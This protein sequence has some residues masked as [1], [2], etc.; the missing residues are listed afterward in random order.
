V[1]FFGAS[2][3]CSVEAA[4]QPEA[5]FI[6]KS[7]GWE[8]YHAVMSD[9]DKVRDSA[10]TGLEMVVISKKAIESGV[11]FDT[12]RDGTHESFGAG[13][14]VNRLP[15]VVE[16]VIENTALPTLGSFTVRDRGTLRIDLENGLTIFAVHL[17]SNQNPPCSEIDQAGD[18]ILTQDPELSERLKSYYDKG[19]RAATDQHLHNARLRERMM[20]AVLVE[21][22][23]AVADGR[24]VLITGDFNIAFERGKS[25]T[26]HD[27]CR[28]KDFSCAQA[29]FPREACRGDGFDDTLAIL[30]RPLVGNRPWTFLTRTLGRTYDSERFADLAIDH[31]AVPS[32]QSSMFATATKSEDN[33]GSDHFAVTTD[34]RPN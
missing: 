18:A 17:K 32:D 24:T 5:E 26:R 4:G 10:Y 16:K 22:N 30:E 3:L 12:D 21:A 31:M 29:P 23:K 7:L 13:E 20:A 14:L 28:L 15:Q 27:D 9:F 8:N 2:G 33:Y 25:G 6:A 1:P 11:E 19:F 34:F